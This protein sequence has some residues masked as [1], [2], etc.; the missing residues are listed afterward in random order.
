MRW[1]RMLLPIGLLPIWMMTI[2]PARSGSAAVFRSPSGDTVFPEAAVGCAGDVVHYS[3]RYRGTTY[4]G[5]LWVNSP[6]GQACE[7]GRGRRVT[8]YFEERSQTG[9]DWCKGQL[10]LYLTLDPQ[11]GSS[12]QWSNIV[13]VP[14]HTC[15]GAGT[16]PRLPL[17]YKFVYHS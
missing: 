6:R 10:T 8:G 3:T 11:G 12:A 17:I 7:G 14:G 5:T 15:S 16:A 9:T 13:A 4:Q 2:A 1:N